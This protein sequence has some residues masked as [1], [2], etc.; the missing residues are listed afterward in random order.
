MVSIGSLASE[1]NRRT[2]QAAAQLY[3]LFFV[4]GFRRTGAIEKAI[5][6]HGQNL[7]VSGT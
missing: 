7:R 4:T 3:T 1:E 5:V 2:A 6:T